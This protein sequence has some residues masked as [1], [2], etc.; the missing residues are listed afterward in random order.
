MSRKPGARPTLRDVARSVGLDASTVSRILNGHAAA[1]RISPETE[2]RV[3]RSAEL[4]GYR[5]NTVARALRTGRTLIIGMVIPDVANLY[6]AMIA[7]GAEDAFAVGGYSLLISSTD[8]DLTRSRRQIVAMLSAQT[9]G[10][11]YGVARLT[12]DDVL[13]EILDW[14]TPVVQFNRMT[15]EQGVSAVV[16]DSRAGIHLGVR[17]LVELGHRDVVHVAGPVL[18]STG[19]A[20]R[21]AFD[22]ALAEYGL[23]GESEPTGRHT[24]S[25]GYRATQALLDRVPDVTAIVAGNDRLALG[26][27]DALRARGLDCPADVSVVGFND[28][29]YADRVA[30]PLTTVHVP[31]YDLGR[32]A[33]GLLLETIKDP[34]RP[35]VT[36]LVPPELVVRD[37]T[38]AP[39]RRF[40]EGRA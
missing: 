6:Q 13:E 16:P 20:R 23:K 30:P 17:H 10:I 22:E 36:E 38:A 1:G 4:L 8:N 5:G 19:V 24:E 18:V 27:I 9:E 3:L 26:A 2:Q 40:E 33:A 37:S 34:A 21:R 29:P 35:P 12:G 39:R 15:E 14:G 11:L 28:M 25:E 31:Q 32:R 7:R